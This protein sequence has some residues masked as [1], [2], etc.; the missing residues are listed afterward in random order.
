M[1]NLGVKGLT[2][3]NNQLYLEGKKSTNVPIQNMKPCILFDT[4]KAEPCYETN[5]INEEP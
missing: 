5:K 4:E 2:G 3:I 1:C